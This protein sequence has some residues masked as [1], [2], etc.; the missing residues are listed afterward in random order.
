[1]ILANSRKIEVIFNEYTDK[2][3]PDQMG[4]PLKFLE[5]IVLCDGEEV[6]RDKLSDQLYLQDRSFLRQFEDWV[7]GVGLPFKES[8]SGCDVGCE[9]C[10]K[11]RLFRVFRFE[12][13]R[14]VF[15]FKT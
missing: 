5:R 10:N 9:C 8:Q 7:S 11:R 4:F 6:Y 13:F 15:K 1:M 12:F 14:K 3:Y 2:E